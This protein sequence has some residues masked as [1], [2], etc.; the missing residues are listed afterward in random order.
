M[1]NKSVVFLITVLL[2]LFLVSCKDTSDIKIG[3]AVSLTGMDNTTGQSFV[4][5]VEY[6]IDEINQNGGVNGRKLELIIGDDENNPEKARQVDQELIDSGVCTIIGHI[7][8][9]IT[10]AA[11]PVIDKNQMLLFSPTV[12]SYDI[13]ANNDLLISLGSTSPTTQKAVVDYMINHDHIEDL[14]IIYDENNVEFAQFWIDQLN[15]YLSNSDLKLTKTVKSNSLEDRSLLYEITQEALENDPDGVLII[16]S[17]LETAFISQQL[18]KLNPEIKKYATQWSFNEM[19]IEQ[20]GTAVENLLLITE[21]D[22]FSENEWAQAYRKGNV[23]S[24]GINPG[25]SSFAYETMYILY[26]ALRSSGSTNPIDLRDEI[27]RLKNFQGLSG[28]ITIDSKGLSIRDYYLYTIKEGN[29]TK[30][31]IP[32]D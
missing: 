18:C 19:V 4:Y 6:A 5:A 25:I 1:N 15:D 28:E 3:L 16:A 26:Q 23:E 27:L 20:G 31:I 12:S 29:F 13:V 14:I 32:E 11:L 30:L 21:Y 8:S 22:R 2:I 9:S 24:Y 17:P 10:K 7:T